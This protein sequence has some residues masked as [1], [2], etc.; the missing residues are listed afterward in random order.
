MT[1]FR[2]NLLNRMIRI[3]GFEHEIV[4]DFAAMC[5]AWADNDWNNKCLA[6]LVESHEA[7]PVFLED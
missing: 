5:E 3:Y 4:L 7:D 1:K 2:E 6:I